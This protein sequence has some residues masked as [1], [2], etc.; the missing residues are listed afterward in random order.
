MSKLTFYPV[1]NADTFV[2]DLDGGEKL[3]FDYAD[4]RNEADKDDKCCDLSA[5]LRADLGKRTDYDVAIFT[6]LDQDHY[7]GSTDFFYLEH[8]EAYQGKVDGKDR[9]KMGVMWVPA[10][11]LT[12]K[13]KEPRVQGHPKGGPPPLTQQAWH[14]CV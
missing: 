12:E 11:V 3:I 6:H 10:A 14:P 8:D 2:I 1:G 5:E 9:V 4:R 7:D 13:L